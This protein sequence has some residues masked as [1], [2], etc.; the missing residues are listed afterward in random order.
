MTK[1]QS[2]LPTPGP[3]RTTRVLVSDGRGAPPQA[4]PAQRI[5][6]DQASLA[7]RRL[8]SSSPGTSLKMAWAAALVDH[9]RG[10][11]RHQLMPIDHSPAWASWAALGRQPNKVARIV[12]SCGRR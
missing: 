10:H 11:H 9:A 6:F 5:R 8:P 12:Q 3:R 2:S 1:G 7:N 4:T